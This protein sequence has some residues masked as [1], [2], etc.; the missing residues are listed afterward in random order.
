MGWKMTR[1]DAKK[2]F[3]EYEKCILKKNFERSLG[4]NTIH[5]VLALEGQTVRLPCHICQRPDQDSRKSKIDWQFLRASDTRI[6]Y[7]RTDKRIHIDGRTRDLIFDSVDI[8]DAGQYYC[9]DL[10]YRAIEEIYQVDVL[11]KER[12]RVIKENTVLKNRSALLQNFSL[13][14]N[15]LMTFTLWSEWSECNQ[16]GQI[17]SRRKIGVCMVKKIKPGL[18]IRPNDLPLMA[19]YPDGVP[20]RSTALSGDIAKIKRIA[21]RRSETIIGQCNI[22]C[23]TTPA[24][25]VVTDKRGKVIET[26]EAGYYSLKDKPTLPPMV[27]RKVVY[28]EAGKHL[29]LKCPGK[30]EAKS[31]IRWQNGSVVLNPLT[32]K[33]QTR[34][35]VFTDTINRLHIRVTRLFDSAPYNCWAGKRHVATIKV[36]VTKPINKN[37]KNNIT[38]AGLL[39]T[40]ISITIICICVCKNK[41]KKT[42]K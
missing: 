41:A 12:R 19:L 32:I 23:P 27:I 42:A 26:V 5:A 20:C 37:L 30:S 35:R 9:M 7:V 2:L 3:R 8:L 29:V 40:V 18:P 13:P 22:T 4:S 38:Y 17:G 11:L 16:C 28:E 14:E 34:G 6:Q 21:L 25:I 10:N 15:N 39:T 36:V 31:L 24:F 1:D 33:R